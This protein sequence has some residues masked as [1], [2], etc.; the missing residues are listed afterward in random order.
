M[1]W[2]YLGENNTL[3]ICERCQVITILSMMDVIEE[4]IVDLSG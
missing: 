4:M 2:K 3:P 1:N